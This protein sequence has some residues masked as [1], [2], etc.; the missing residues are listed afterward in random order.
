MNLMLHLSTVKK[1][2][3]RANIENICKTT[4]TSDLIISHIVL[5]VVQTSL[6]T[7]ESGH[8]CV[9]VQ[10]CLARKVPA[11]MDSRNNSSMHP[12]IAEIT[13]SCIHG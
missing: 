8:K 6:G 1:N 12:W 5:I 9:W 13:L 2:Q 7:N 11:S 10:T 3:C 4:L